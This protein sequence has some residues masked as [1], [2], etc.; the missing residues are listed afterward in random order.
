MQCCLFLFW[1][2]AVVYGILMQENDQTL[3][4]LSTGNMRVYKIAALTYF[5]LL[6]SILREAQ[7]SR[8]QFI[9]TYYVEL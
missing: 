8:N 3:I 6:V 4:S 2:N 1:E 7:Q 5:R 9:T